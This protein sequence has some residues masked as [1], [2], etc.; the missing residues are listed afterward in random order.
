FLGFDEEEQA[1]PAAPAIK[2]I[3]TPAAP[4]QRGMSEAVTLDTGYVVPAKLRTSARVAQL[5]KQLRTKLLAFPDEADQWSRH[6]KA[7]QD[8]LIGRL[9][10]ILSKM[11]VSLSSNELAE[12]S[13]A[14]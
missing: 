4:A 8:I 5:R 2:S 14:L 12:L 1:Q 9:Q 10:T 13:E 7:K 11:G 6:D 3:A